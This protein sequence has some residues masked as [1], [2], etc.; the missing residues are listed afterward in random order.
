MRRAISILAMLIFSM[1]AGM[2]AFGEF[3][4]SEFNATFPGM[5]PGLQDINSID[6]NQLIML[7][8]N[9]TAI[10]APSEG[11]LATQFDF[12]DPIAVVG[13]LFDIGG[14]AVNSILNLTFGITLIA[15]KFQA[16]ISIVVFIGAVNFMIVAFGA[17]EMVAFLNSVI[18]GGGAN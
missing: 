7:D 2:W 15:I 11:F 1:N 4:N 12:L 13:S 14:F 9:G 18:R 10:N 5:P 3:D 6:Q 8:A 16:P 17:M